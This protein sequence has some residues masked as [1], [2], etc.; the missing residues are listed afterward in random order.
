VSGMFF[1]DCR[2]SISSANSSQFVFGVCPYFAPSSALGAGS[3]HN[4]VARSGC[5]IVSD[6]KQDVPVFI[7]LLGVSARVSCES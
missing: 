6:S 2:Q 5:H 3:P 7:G 1:S 4:L